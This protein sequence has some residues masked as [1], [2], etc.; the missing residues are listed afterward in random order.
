[1]WWAIDPSGRALGAGPEVDADLLAA[2]RAAGAAAL[3]AW[4]FEEE[5]RV[6]VAVPAAERC[7]FVLARGT[8]VPGWLGSILPAPEVWVPPVIGVLAVVLLAMGPI[9]ARIR[10]L[11]DQVQ[12][13]QRSAWRSRVDV[14]GDDELA[15]LA[16]AFDD[17]ARA[18]REEMA[19]KDQRE[20]ALREFLQDTSHDLMLPLT[21]LQGHLAALR[22]VSDA[23]EVVDAMGEAHYLGGMVRNLAAAARLAAS[24][25]PARD[26]L[27]LAVVIERVIARH[28]PIA[29]TRAISLEHAAPEA[30]VRIVGDLTLV[31]QAVSNVVYNAVRHHHPSGGHIAVVLDVDG[32]RFA[33]R[34]IDDGPG[35]S[36]A[37]LSRLGDRGFRSDEARTRSPDGQGLGLS[38]TRRVVEAHGWEVVFQR[39]EEG[40]LEVVFEGE[41]GER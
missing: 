11:S 17:A 10:G 13:L 40:G 4:W 6:L 25:E 30:P 28:R 14:G 24:P 22:A 41:V 20:Q 8:T 3:P 34:V 39:R 38:I 19:A 29:R 36:D 32:G 23:P 31:E 9:L 33:L 7:T 35:L 12:A 27:D 37:Q 21:V 26:E 5:V 1:M 18:V 16:R 15:D 2:A